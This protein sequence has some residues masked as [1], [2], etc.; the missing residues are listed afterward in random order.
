M[1][2]GLVSIKSIAREA[3]KRTKIAVA[4]TDPRVDPVGACVGMRGTRVR[5]ITDELGNE[6]IDIVPYDEDIKK[7]AVNALLP[8]KVQSVEVDEE[9]HELRIIVS[10]EQSKVAFGRKAQ[11]VRLSAKLIGWN[12][13]LCDEN[14]KGRAP[15]IAEQLKAA[16]GKLAETAGVSGE[17][18]GILVANGFITV[19]GIKAADLSTLTAL[20]GIDA[21]EITEA[22]ERLNS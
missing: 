11:N 14:A 18:A 1:H 5:R 20:D 21:A 4:S 16:A 3:G 6:R 17:C 2:D 12:I 9:K 10:E 13:K 22:F 7:F 19:D 8:A 15:S